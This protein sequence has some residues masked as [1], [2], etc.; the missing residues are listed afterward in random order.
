MFDKITD[1]F[2]ILGNGFLTNDIIRLLDNKN[3]NSNILTNEKNLNI[4][5]KALRYIQ[6]IKNG[7]EIIVN[8]NVNVDNFDKSLN[9]F[10]ISLNALYQSEKNLTI[11]NFN[12]IID[13]SEEQ[14]NN[15]IKFKKIIKKNIDI[16]LKLF[17]SIRK[18][19][20]KEAEKITF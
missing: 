13:I 6:L 2:S 11:E 12:Q 9:S 19:L 16:S 3:I 15:S 5:K 18:H 10:N 20:H 4:L 17:E 7:R 14:I 1:M 8:N